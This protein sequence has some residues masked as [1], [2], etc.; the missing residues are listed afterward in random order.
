MKKVI[1]INNAETYSLY[2]EFIIKYAPDLKR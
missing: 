1:V 2:D